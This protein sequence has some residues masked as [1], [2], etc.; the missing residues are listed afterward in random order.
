MELVKHEE[1][2]LSDQKANEI[3]KGLDTI[4]QERE[5]LEEQYVE[6]VMEEITP[7]LSEK[8]RD[9]RLRIRDNRTKGLNKWHKANKEFFLQGGK[10]VDAIKNKNIIHNE[11]MEQKLLA[12]E[13]YEENLEKERKHKLSKQ[14]LEHLKPYCQEDDLSG[15]D[16]GE[17]NDTMYNSFFNQIKTQHEQRLIEEK[18][19]KEEAEAER[20]RIS[21]IE[22]EN[23]KLQEEIEAKKKAEAKSKAEKE[24]KELA[25]AKKQEELKKAPIKTKLNFWLE[26]FNA[27]ENT[28]ES[29]L[30][31]E[32]LE[33]YQ[34]FIVWSKNK[35]NNL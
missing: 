6:V 18:K 5:V 24:A 30:Q 23:K 25:E 33:K 14:R 10:F 21:K 7:E 16:L 22:E 34:S 20:K 8:A 15:V 4:I 28:E 35:I 29:I 27:P 26:G 13:K 1:F 12:I 9:L 19:A 17:M 2:G 11:R 3:T 31:E 32:I